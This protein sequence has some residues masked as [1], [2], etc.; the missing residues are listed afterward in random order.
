MAIVEVLDKQRIHA[1]IGTDPIA[2]L[3]AIDENLRGVEGI[4]S[5]FASDTE[6]KPVN[7]MVV[8]WGQK[9]L[10]LGSIGRLSAGRLT[11]LEDVVAA[12]PA[13]RGQYDVLLP[14]WASPAI[15]SAFKASALGAEA[16]YAVD[17]DRLNRS[18][19]AAKCER[20]SDP[21]IVKPMFP[22]LA[23]DAPIYVLSLR[24]ALTSV[25][26]VTHLQEDIARIFVY[27]VEGS[28]RHGFGRGALTALAEELLALKVTPTIAIDLAVEDAVR[29]TENA[30]FFQTRAD[31]KVH[32][33]GKREESFPPR[34]PDLGLVRLGRK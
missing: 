30:G 32:V 20:L 34:T 13:D 21:E 11:G 17:R 19:V 15:T 33:A 14:F 24:G 4:V 16:I 9:H 26:A 1:L 10:G 31:L 23:P 12:V 6:A 2:N 22:K 25:A 18:P 28:R 29:M 7:L 8:R 5:V 3:E 27:T